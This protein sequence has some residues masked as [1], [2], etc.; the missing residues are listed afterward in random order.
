M[1]RQIGDRRARLIGITAHIRTREEEAVGFV[2]RG[3]IGRHPH[4][5]SFGDV[6]NLRSVRTGG[7]VERA[8]ERRKAC[9]RQQDRDIDA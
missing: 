9:E 6:L 3:E 5:S 2:F 8:Q 1:R 4:R 7:A